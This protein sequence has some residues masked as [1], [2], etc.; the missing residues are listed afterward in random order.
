MNLQRGRNLPI[1]HGTKHKKKSP[2]AC[3]R[4]EVLCRSQDA[5]DC[6]SNKNIRL[7][8]QLKEARKF[9]ATFIKKKKKIL[10]SIQ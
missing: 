2:E 4:R 8:V 5:C 10:P 9:L 1:H 6:W 3:D 7:P